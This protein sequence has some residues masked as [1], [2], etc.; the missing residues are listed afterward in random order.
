MKSIRAMEAVAG[1]QRFVSG[2]RVAMLAP[3]ALLS[4]GWGFA[5]P[6]WDITLLGIGLHRFFLFHSAFA[7]V[8]LRRFLRRRWVEAWNKT[9]VRVLLGGFALGIGFHLLTD[10]F[11]PKSVVF[12][13][14]SAVPG[15]LLDDELWLLGHAVWALW[16]GRSLLKSALA[17]KTGASRLLR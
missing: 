7:I 6:D 14:G 2:A 12:P 9:T 4:V 1:L 10:L 5:F 16:L 17:K 13:W 15:T 3:F 8:G 11:Q